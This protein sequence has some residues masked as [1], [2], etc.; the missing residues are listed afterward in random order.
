MVSMLRSLLVGSLTAVATFTVSQYVTAPSVQTR[1]TNLSAASA[2]NF[3]V[4]P[5]F[6]WGVFVDHN[7]SLAASVT[8]GVAV[9]GRLLTHGSHALSTRVECTTNACGSTP[10]AFGLVHQVLNLDSTRWANLTPNMTVY[11]STSTIVLRGTN[12]SLDVVDLNKLP[13]ANFSLRIS[14]PSTATVLINVAPKISKDLD[15]LRATVLP[16]S[17][18]P[19]LIWNFGN[20]KDLQLP[21]VTFI[22]SVLAPEANV[23][24]SADINGDVIAENLRL[25]GAKAMTIHDNRD[26]FRGVLPQYPVTRVG[27]PVVAT[28][29]QPKV[30]LRIMAAAP[31][32]LSIIAQG[33]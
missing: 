8:G 10:L 11:L 6:P 12:R 18:I 7:A 19:T 27:V 15:R 29:T 32:N 23:I 31:K 4:V 28:G 22:G 14:A 2:P 9:G 1:S 3:G 5:K 30:P 33:R 24:G 26:G 17:T 21:P 16:V 13:S 25:S 20:I